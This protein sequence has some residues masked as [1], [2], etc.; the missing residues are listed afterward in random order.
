MT[1]K[2]LSFG[3]IALYSMASAGLNILGIT[4]GT[5]ILYFYAPPP[6]S[7][8]PQYLPIALIGVLMT[9]AS[10]W[11]AVIDPFIGHW[12]DTLRSRWGRRRPFLMFAAPFVL[13]GAILLWTPPNSSTFVN[14][15]YFMFIILVYH[16][17]Y[18]LVGIPY[19]GT[20]PEMAPDSH[21]RVGLSYWKNAFGILGVLIG[22]LV[23]APL[24]SSIGP[25]AMGIAVGAV[26][27]VSI[28]LTL[29]GLRETD[30]PLGEKM[31]ALEG[32]K[33]TCYNHL[34]QLPLSHGG[35]L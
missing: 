17:S 9:V 6:D 22:S 26:A 27:I 14:A 28:L 5:W 11:D 30:R 18:S 25:V 21:Q 3:R 16:T 10:L 8:R 31:S 12:S 4:I 15:V 23:A 24:F 7:G 32:F 19:D 13:L 1:E 20:L 2:K 29:F 33:A 34:R 35:D